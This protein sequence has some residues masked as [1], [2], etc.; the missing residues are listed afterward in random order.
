MASQ[1]DKPYGTVVSQAGVHERQAPSTD[2]PALGT[3]PS[4]ATVGLRGKVRAQDIDGNNIW[5]LLRDRNAWV[6]ARYVANTGNVPW[7][8]EL[9]TAAAA[10]DGD[11]A[12]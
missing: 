2:A 4:G 12:G 7:V 6:A 3:L 10:A 8:K 5:Y 11:S 1:P 9:A